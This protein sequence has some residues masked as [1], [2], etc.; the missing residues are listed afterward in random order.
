MNVKIAFTGNGLQIGAIAKTRNAAI[1]LARHT[2][3][4]AVR[5][6]KLAFPQTEGMS[7]GEVAFWIHSLPPTELIANMN[8]FTFSAQAVK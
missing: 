6:G 8:G 5:R 7:K 4:Q 3:A 1:D 2:I